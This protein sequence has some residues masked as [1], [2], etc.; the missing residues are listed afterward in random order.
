RDSIRRLSDLSSLQV[1][2]DTV[3]FN[4]TAAACAEAAEVRSPPDVLSFGG[5]LKACRQGGHWQPAV[6]LLSMMDTEGIVPNLITVSTSTSACGHLEQWTLALQL[7]AGHPSADLVLYNST[8]SAC[9][10]GA[11]WPFALQLLVDMPMVR[12]TP[13]Q[14]SCS[15]GI[16]ACEASSR[17]ASFQF[18]IPEGPYTLPLWN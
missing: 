16:T 14:V 9:E 13:N 7:F 18:S 5:A 10:K 6:H 15:T 2:P 3:R 1:L 11:Q 12:A 8:I 4:A 17:P